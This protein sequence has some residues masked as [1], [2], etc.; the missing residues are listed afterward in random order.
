M[1]KTTLAGSLCALSI[2]FSG[3]LYANH[4]ESTENSDFSHISGAGFSKENAL[5]ISRSGSF[6]IEIA[7][8]KALPLFTGPGERLWVPG[9]DPVILSGD[10]FE[11]DTVF[12]TGHN[13]KTTY[14]QVLDYDKQTKHARY[15]RINPDSDTGTV[16]VLLKANGR[17]GSTVHVTYKL[18]ALT[19]MGNKKLLKHYDQASYAKMMVEWRDL[20]VSHMDKI[21]QHL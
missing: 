5:T 1:N 14:W 7:P 16:D 9:W 19:S 12:L 18:T 17:G 3:N 2:F 8:E 6:E 21:N 13:G 15:H 11:P 4:H 20:I 10:G